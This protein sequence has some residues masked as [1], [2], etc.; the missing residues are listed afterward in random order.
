MGAITDL[1][2]LI[3]LVSRPISFIL[4]TF[5][6][7][8]ESIIFT[9]SLGVHG[10][11]KNELLIPDHI[12]FFV[13]SLVVLGFTEVMDYAILSPIKWIMPFRIHY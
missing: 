3:K 7:D 2:S 4:D 5:L 9:I 1:A 13:S 10:V 11:E 12:F 6:L 8:M